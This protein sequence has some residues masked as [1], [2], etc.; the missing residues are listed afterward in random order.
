MSVQADTLTMTAVL[1]VAA[2]LAALLLFAPLFLSAAI[3]GVVRLVAVLVLAAG[4]V[5]SARVVPSAVPAD[6]AGLGLAVVTEVF[7][8]AVLAFGV[9]C[10]FAAFQLGG[11]LLDFQMGFGVANV[12]DPATSAPAAPRTAR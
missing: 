11:Q 10:A 4:I 7:V 2:R 12:I 5:A 8:G 3:P 1:L 9:F 6:L